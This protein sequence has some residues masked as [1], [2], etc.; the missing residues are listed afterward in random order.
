M[1]QV[2]DPDM[3][4]P[5]QFARPDE[6]LWAHRER[7]MGLRSLDKGAG[8]RRGTLTEQDMVRT[9]GATRYP[10]GAEPAHRD[11]TEQF[12]VEVLRFLQV[13]DGNGPGRDAF[14]V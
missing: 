3:P 14:D 9:D 5:K 8:N 7:V 10:G 1:I 2:L 12:P 11:E 4:L 6:G 13:V